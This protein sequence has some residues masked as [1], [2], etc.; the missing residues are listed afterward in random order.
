[1]AAKSEPVIEAEPTPKEKSNGITKM[2]KTV[3]LIRAQTAHDIPTRGISNDQDERLG[4][5]NKLQAMNSPKKQKFSFSSI[6]HKKTTINN[7]RATVG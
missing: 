4:T 1:M 3:R 6:F 2:L 5:L 7:K